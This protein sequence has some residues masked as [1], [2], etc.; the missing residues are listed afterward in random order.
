MT[1]RKTSL[2]RLRKR[3]R[4]TKKDT[5]AL[6]D[7]TLIYSRGSFVKVKSL[8]RTFD[9]ETYMGAKSFNSFSDADNYAIKRR[10]EGLK[11]RVLRRFESGSPSPIVYIRRK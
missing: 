6:S 8:K 9:G 2:R 1:E 7:G 3:A 11:A 5:Q 4:M 10:K